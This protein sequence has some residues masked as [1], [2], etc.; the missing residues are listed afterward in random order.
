VVERRPA[1]LRSIRPRHG[2]LQLGP[3]AL[4]IDH[5]REPLEVVALLRQ[6]GQT[7]LNVEKPSRPAH[8]D[9]P[10]LHAEVDQIAPLP[11]RFLEVSR[12]QT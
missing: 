9:P 5:V 8:P 4:E 12:W 6:A 10:L 1:A 11:P 7:I 3:K 2:A